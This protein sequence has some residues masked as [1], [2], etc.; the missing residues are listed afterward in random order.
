MSIR[1]AILLPCA[2]AL[3]M[4]SCSTDLDVTAPYKENTVVY[5]LLDK[6]S[7]RQYV[8][9]NKAFLGPDNAFVYASIP[10]SSEYADGQLQ[11]EVKEIKNGTVVNTYALYDTIMDNHAPGI[12]A[13]PQHKLYYFE[14]TLDSS[15]IYRLEATAKGNK[16]STQT[17][18][19]AR[20]Q[21]T[22]SIF[23][24]P[25]R[26]VP[27]GGN[28]YTSQMIRWNSAV[29]AKRYDLSYRFNWDEI[30]G[31]DTVSKSFVQPITTV[32]TDNTTGG[33]ALEA[34]MAGEAF[35]Q[36]VAIRVGNNP[37]VS[38][39]IYRGVDI[40]WA[41]A[42]EDLHVYLQLSNPISGLVEDRPVYTNVDNG[43][44]LF[45]TRRFFEIKNKEL[46][47]N[48]VP[49]LV[50]G[51]YTAGLHFCVPGSSSPFGCE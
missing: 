20:T 45:S 48:T 34:A 41:V 44:G 36:T 11:A 1:P 23:N 32:V 40:M 35:F 38:K 31:A 6:D 4:S 14:A 5:A 3:V 13:G 8:K 47:A 22:G 29:N 21:V 10:D 17:N 50:Q 28:G 7:L 51:Q 12:F 9:I 30:I 18:V 46:D 16:I 15:A 49:E 19:V 26:L 2:A 43:Y 24:Q 27:T 39:R 25:L 33:A 37:A 42:G